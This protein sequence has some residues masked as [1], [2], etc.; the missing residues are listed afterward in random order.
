MVF[1]GVSA[2]VIPHPT[3]AQTDSIRIDADRP[4][5]DAAGAVAPL[6][7]ICGLAKSS[8]GKVFQK[9]LSWDTTSSLDRRER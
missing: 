7:G 2:F 9:L 1:M 4:Y 3:I 5:T 6:H 8:S